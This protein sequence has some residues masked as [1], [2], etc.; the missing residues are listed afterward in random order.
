MQWYQS[1]DPMARL[2]MEHQLT[3]I[4]GIHNSTNALTYKLYLRHKLL[5]AGGTLYYN[6]TS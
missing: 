4:D 1:G 3:F 5:M 2:I 6:S